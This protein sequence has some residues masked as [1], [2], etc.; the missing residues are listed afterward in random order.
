MIDDF[1]KS[2]AEL[3]AKEIFTK[4]FFRTYTDSWY[5]DELFRFEN[6]C[7]D[8]KDVNLQKTK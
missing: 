2:L 4:D 1:I 5:L 6:Q 3:R 7:V 8:T